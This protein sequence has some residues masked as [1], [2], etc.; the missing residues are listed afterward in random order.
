MDEAQDT[1]PAQWKIIQDLSDE[2]F[3][4]QGRDYAVNRTVFV[5]GDRKQSIYSFQGADTA[6]F[7]MAR[8]R[9]SGQLGNNQKSL[10]EI[11]L[12]VSYRS[13]P[14]VLQAV[15]TAFAKGRLPRTGYGKQANDERDHQASRQ[16]EIGVFELWP[17]VKK[18]EEEE[19]DYWQVFGVRMNELFRRARTHHDGDGEVLRLLHVLVHAGVDA[20]DAALRR[21]LS[22]R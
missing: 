5:V 21:V 18:P 22:A 14:D 7:E 17:L 16:S 10:Q 3:A 20:D 11:G 8:Q 13:T 6:A 19:P 2:F 12:T 1:S 4:G 9:F 15:D